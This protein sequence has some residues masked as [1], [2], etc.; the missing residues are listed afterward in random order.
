MSLTER[1]ANKFSKELTIENKE[2]CLI[3]IYPSYLQKPKLHPG[4]LQGSVVHNNVAMIGL[5]NAAKKNLLFI[6]KSY[7]FMVNLII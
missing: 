3:E 4:K 1:L 5:S 2:F 7:H 6:F